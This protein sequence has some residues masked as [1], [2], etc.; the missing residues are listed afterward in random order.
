MT[1]DLREERLTKWTRLPFK[2][3]PITPHVWRLPRM[4]G[5][6]IGYSKALGSPSTMRDIFY[7][8]CEAAHHAVALATV[9][10]EKVVHTRDASMVEASNC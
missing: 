1:H 5:F 10:A 9:L 7:D 3:L 8:G 2:H 4:R 6:L